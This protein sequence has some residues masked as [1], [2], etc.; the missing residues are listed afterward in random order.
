MLIKLARASGMCNTAAGLVESALSY[1][2]DERKPVRTKMLK[3]ALALLDACKD[4]MHAEI[5]VRAAELND[6]LS[7]EYRSLL[8]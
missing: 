4:E 7:A 6:N 5:I 8:Q 3:E 2:D 1:C